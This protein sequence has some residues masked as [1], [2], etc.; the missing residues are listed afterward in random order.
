MVSAVMAS[1]LTVDVRKMLPQGRLEH[2]VIDTMIA[3]ILLEHVVSGLFKTTFCSL[4]GLREI[5]H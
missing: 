5:C 1:V 4:S 2:F 3:K